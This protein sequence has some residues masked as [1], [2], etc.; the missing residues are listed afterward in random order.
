MDAAKRN[1]G[2]WMVVELG[3]GQV[4]GLPES[5]DAAAFYGQIAQRAAQLKVS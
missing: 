2:E 5:A 3:D 4:A 1:S